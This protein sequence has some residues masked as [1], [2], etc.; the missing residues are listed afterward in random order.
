MADDE[1]L[2]TKGFSELRAA[3][4]KFSYSEFLQ[5]PPNI[6]LYG[7]H[8]VQ[9]MSYKAFGKNTPR[10]M[11]FNYYTT[12][13]SLHDAL[14]FMEN[15]EENMKLPRKLL[16]IY[17]SQPY[18]NPGF[19]FNDSSLINY[20][21]K[22]VGIKS[23]D[24]TYQNRLT[25]ALTNLKIYLDWKTFIFGMLSKSFPECFNLDFKKNRVSENNSNVAPVSSLNMLLINKAISFLPL[26][27]YK[28]FIQNC[29]D[30]NRKSQSNQIGYR[31]DGSLYDMHKESL[32]MGLKNTRDQ[33]PW[34]M[35]DVYKSEEIVNR[36]NML[37][38]N[39]DLKVIYFVPP[40]TLHNKAQ[41]SQLVY[42]E[43]INRIRK[44]GSIVFDYRKDAKQEYMYDHRHVNDIFFQKL[45]SDT[46]L[47]YPGIFEEEN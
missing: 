26:D 27:N 36:I 2:I 18:L 22:S 46:S 40:H 12:H 39:N 8:I 29:D 28:S 6:G 11:F 23:Q 45:I 1:I 9:H 34:S 19:L 33:A 5:Q 35:E 14:L 37:A 4:L 10:H 43:F 7:H 42:D 24:L 20:W 41:I 38:R 21:K 16:F 30:G 32:A 44:D 47:L 17:L 31:W 15:Q 25:S 3:Y 13:L